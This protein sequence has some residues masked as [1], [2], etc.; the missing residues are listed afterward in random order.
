MPEP[1]ITSRCWCGREVLLR[2]GVGTGPK[3]KRSVL[4]FETTLATIAIITTHL[5]QRGFSCIF[6]CFFRRRVKQPTKNLPCF[7]SRPATAMQAQHTLCESF[8]ESDLYFSIHTHCAGKNRKSFF[9]SSFFGFVCLRTGFFLGPFRHR[10]RERDWEEKPGTCPYAC[11]ATVFSPSSAPLALCV[12]SV[13]DG[14][15]PTSTHPTTLFFLV[16]SPTTDR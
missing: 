5:L 16:F 6:I 15:T 8:T 14:L 11:V 10:V 9:F 4:H 3:N 13:F 7:F 1:C 12:S 2:W